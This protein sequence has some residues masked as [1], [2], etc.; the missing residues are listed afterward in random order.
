MTSKWDRRF[1]LS[2]LG[3]AVSAA[4]LLAQTKKGEWTY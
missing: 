4:V 1:R 2:I 3:L